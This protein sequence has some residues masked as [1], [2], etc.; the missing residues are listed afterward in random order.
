MVSDDELMELKQLIEENY[1]FSIHNFIK[2]K[3]G[4]SSDTFKL[5]IRK[6]DFLC[7]DRIFEKIFGKSK[8]DKYL[9]LKIFFKKTTKEDIEHEAQL[10]DYLWQ[11]N[12]PT[13][14]I[15]KT[16]TN[17]AWVSFGKRYFCIQEYIIGRTYSTYTLPDK[18]LIQSASLL[19]QL[20]TLMNEYSAKDTT[21]KRVYRDELTNRV[22]EKDIA[23]LISHI[24][25]STSAS[26]ELKEYIIESLG[27]LLSIQPKV[28]EYIGAFKSMPYVYSHGDYITS[29]F[30]CKNGKIRGV[31]DFSS[32]RETIALSD[33]MNNYL[34][35]ATECINQDF[36]SKEKFMTYV[37]TYIKNSTLPLTRNDY[38]LMPRVCL[39]IYFNRSFDAHK[40]LIK[41]IEKV[42]ASISRA[43]KKTNQLNNI[44]KYLDENQLTLQEYLCASHSELC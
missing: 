39:C 23:K 6:N 12:F 22:S 20:Q 5:R 11:N 42:G 14:R 27:Y 19:G 44:C 31:I 40:N 10:L 28:A 26:A 34:Y 4:K 2:I 3:P 41:R 25:V 35:S 21:S 15:L 7:F 29:Q 30:L 33:L 38:V 36:I 24:D 13:A 17:T 16:N 8:K 9:F 18:Y 32:A 37:E 1:N 43:L